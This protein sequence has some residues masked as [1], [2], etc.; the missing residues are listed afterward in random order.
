MALKRWVLM[1]ALVLLPEMA[2]ARD[3]R[4]ITVD[5]APWAYRPEAPAGAFPDIVHELEKRTGHSIAVALQSFA[6]VERDLETG[7]QDCSILMWIEARSRLVERGENVYPMPFGVIARKDVPLSS[8]DDLARL[9]VSVVRGVPISPRFDG[10]DS[11][12]KDFDK[13]YLVGLRKLEHGRVEAVAGAL[14]TISYIAA[15]N[16]LADMLG[17]PL[18]LHTVPLALQCSRRSA[19]LDVMPQLNEAIRAM[20]SDGTLARILTNNHYH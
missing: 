14:P 10:D 3:L 11:I 6:R 16:D 15:D 17:K 5:A 18:V 9:A 2:A 4:F 13:D 20:S 7:E 19:N 8:Y 12:R 1:A